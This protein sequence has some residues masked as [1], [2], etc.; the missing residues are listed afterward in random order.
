MILNED[1]AHELKLYIWGLMSSEIMRK[2]PLDVMNEI[3]KM[4]DSATKHPIYV[5]TCLQGGTHP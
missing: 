3:N 2:C 1:Q 5:P 4:I